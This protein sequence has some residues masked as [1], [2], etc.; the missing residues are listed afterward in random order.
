V[1]ADGSCE[2]GEAPMQVG[3]SD[4]SEE[5]DGDNAVIAER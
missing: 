4:K 2:A 3:R 5:L 1:H